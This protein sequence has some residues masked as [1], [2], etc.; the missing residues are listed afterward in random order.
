MQDPRKLI[1]LDNGATSFPKPPA[2]AAAVS[3]FLL[4]VG[5]SPGRSGHRLSQEAARVVFACREAVAGLIGAP[6]SKRVVFGL[7]AT[8]GLNTAI[9]G[10]LRQGDRVV[11]TSME[12]NSVMRPLRDLEHRGVIELHVVT[13]DDTGRLDPHVLEEAVRSRR[14]RLVAAVHASNVTGS[15]IP[16]RE[17]GGICRAAGALLLVDA[18][19]SA[20]ALPIDVEADRVDL[21]AF[22]GHKSL[23]GPQGTGG[24]WAREGI[25]PEPLARGG[26]GSNSELEEQPEFWPD[27]LESGTQN[28]VGLAGLL[29]G[30]Q[31]IAAEGVAAI[32]TR[33]EALVRRLLAGLEEIP[34]LHTHGPDHAEERTPVVSVTFD[35]LFPSEAG[36]LLEEGFNVLTRVGL[37]CAPAAHRTIGTYPQGTVRF[38]PG[39]FTTINDIDTAIEGCRY[40]AAKKTGGR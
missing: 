15:I 25:D 9:Y 19:Q 35:G 36:F 5:G 14:P 24:L 6:D 34:G 18:A 38:S 29:A 27:R 26:T 40:L 30:L 7:N 39:Y 13:C 33:E 10:T 4:K 2:V 17:I 8:Q 16:L 12:H 31:Y 22:T 32:H 1:Y 37:H 28:A 11:T 21:L 20:G 23:F 3:H